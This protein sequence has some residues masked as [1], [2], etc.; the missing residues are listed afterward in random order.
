MLRRRW[1]V[2]LMGVFVVVVLG[3]AA[4]GNEPVEHV[5]ELDTTRWADQPHSV[6]VAGSFNGWDREALAMT[7]DVDGSWSAAAE[8]SPGV[9][10]YK[11][12]VDGDRWINDPG[13]SDAAFE[14]PDGHGGFN[15][16][17]YV[18]PDARELPEPPA[19]GF[20]EQAILFE[21]ADDV[22]VVD[23]DLLFVRVKAQAGDVESA[24]VLL[25]DARAPLWPLGRRVGFETWGTMVR[26]AELPR[27]LTIELVDGEAVHRIEVAGLPEQRVETP[28]W[29]RDAVWYQ[30]FPERFRNGDPSND[31]EDV[32]RWTAEWFATLEGEAAGEENFYRGMGNVWNRRYGG[33]LQGVMQSLP[34]LRELGVNALYLNPVFEG[35]SMHKYDTADFRHIDD[36]FGVAGDLPIEGETVDPDTWRF[37]PSDEVFLELLAEARRQGFRVVI[38]GVFNHVGT[39][40]PFFLD[41]LER[42]PESPYRDWF[43]INSWGDPQRWGSDEPWWRVH[44]RD[45]PEGIQWNAWDGPSG[46]L[47]V[48]RNDPQT[49]LGP[50][51]RQ[52]I[53]DITE[54]WLD[55]N[56]DG[57]PSDGIDGWRLDVPGD[58]A[59][60]F[61]HDWRDLVKGV[62]PEAYISGE[63]WQW[64]HPWLDGEAF[65]AVMN[66]QFA[67]AGQDF[68]VDRET[69]ES[70]TQFDQRLQRIAYSY[71]LAVSLVQQNL[72][73][74]HDT[75]RLASMFV[76]PDRP[77]DGAN[78]LQD[79]GPDYDPRQPTAQERRR[80]LQAVAF[81]VTYLGAP[82]IY[83]GDEA[84]MW[85]PDD[86]SNRQPMTWPGMEFDQSSVGFDRAIFDAYQ[87]A[88]AVRNA[89]PALRHGLYRPVVVDD[90]REVFA[91]ARSLATMEEDGVQARHVYAVFNRSASP[92]AV[93][94]PAEWADGAEVWNLLSERQVE[95]VFE[96]DAVDARPQL[97]VRAGATPLRVREGAVRVRLEP[98]GSAVLTT[99]WDAAD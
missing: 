84:G 14:E 68:F 38:D 5:F 95:V 27:T 55:P 1:T 41:V 39:A 94:V 52:H 65:D 26:A 80:Q 30:I 66:Y 10:L 81:Q 70:P 99:D 35:E 78:R 6:H 36:N 67:I 8:L 82:M 73:D 79:N 97:R 92:Q 45:H 88:V 33:D 13:G 96:D 62:N 17:V 46:A 77:Y 23:G 25:G 42:G 34:Y 56:G 15:S 21:P 22:Q 72:Y 2:W 86:P 87:R 43:E 29:A 51:P 24:R 89:L 63:I 59:L 60:P 50:E 40:H 18:G 98:Y 48:F 85:S 58:I 4:A 3:P 32:Q 28:A 49:G 75:D 54:R 93:E 91:F 31:P 19:G 20:H 74:S 90:E 64:A 12:V 11:F 76:N 61:W 69:R 44:G 71:P 16:A 37:S 83:Y 9:H 57:D 7:R 53:F 47:P